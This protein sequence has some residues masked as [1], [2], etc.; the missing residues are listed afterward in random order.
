MG[1]I[2]ILTIM[3]IESGKN[4][5]DNSMP[6]LNGEYLILLYVVYISHLHKYFTLP[7]YCLSYTSYMDFYR[8]TKVVADFE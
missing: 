8:V 6:T 5:D 4:V 2:I 1:L 7:I 3:L